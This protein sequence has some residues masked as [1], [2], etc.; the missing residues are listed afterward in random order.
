MRHIF[1]ML[2]TLDVHHDIS[3]TDQVMAQIAHQRELRR[4]LHKKRASPTDDLTLAER[5]LKQRQGALAEVMYCIRLHEIV[6][7]CM[8]YRHVSCYARSSIIK[9]CTSY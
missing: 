3:D 9:K 8:V 6:G 5:I 7:V 4:R 2:D 1:D